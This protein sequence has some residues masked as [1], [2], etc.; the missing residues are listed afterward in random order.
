MSGATVADSPLVQD[1]NN[2][3]AGIAVSWIFGESSTRVM[4]D[5]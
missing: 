2:F 5:D 1:K 4:V 3:A